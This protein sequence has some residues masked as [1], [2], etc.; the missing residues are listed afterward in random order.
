MVENIATTARLT[1]HSI[2]YFVSQVLGIILLIVIC[3]GLVVYV[4][5]QSCQQEVEE[6]QDA[7]VAE[8]T[9]LRMSSLRTR[10]S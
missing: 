1:C 6:L 7:D 4:I 8:L 3:V 2:M 10:T 5:R 9:V